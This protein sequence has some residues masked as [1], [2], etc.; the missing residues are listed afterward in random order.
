MDSEFAMLGCMR[1]EMHV[2][3]A[4]YPLNGLITLPRHGFPY[5]FSRRYAI[6]V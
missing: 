5:A 6:L 2:A 3:Y 4:L 1:C